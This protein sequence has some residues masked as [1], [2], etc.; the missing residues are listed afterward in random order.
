[1]DASD[2]ASLLAAGHQSYSQDLVY[3]ERQTKL[4]SEENIVI[5]LPSNSLGERKQGQR[6]IF[7]EHSQS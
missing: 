2:N 1:M 7:Y 5:N 3:M 4:L 6:Y